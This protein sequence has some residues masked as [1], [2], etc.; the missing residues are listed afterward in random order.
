M[1]ASGCKVIWNTQNQEWSIIV[2]KAKPESNQ[3]S[4]PNFYF[5]EKYKGMEK[6]SK[7]WPEGKE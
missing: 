2:S 1:Y 6:Q 7:Q 5:T 3:A 4:M